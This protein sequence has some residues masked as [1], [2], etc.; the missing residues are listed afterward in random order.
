MTVGCKIDNALERAWLESGKESGTWRESAMELSLA[1]W[2]TA[3][4][5]EYPEHMEKAFHWLTGRTGKD[6]FIYDNAPLLVEVLV[7]E[8]IW[9]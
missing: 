6:G 5:D 1:C 3:F 8:K 7:R 9:D 2:E 4:D